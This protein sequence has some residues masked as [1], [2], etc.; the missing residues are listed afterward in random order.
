MTGVTNDRPVGRDAVV[1]AV[2]DAAATLFAER[3]PA[4]VSLREVAAAANVNLGL[5]HRYVGS[6]DDLLAAALTL[7]PGPEAFPGGPEVVV[8]ALLVSPDADVHR[9][10]RLFVQAALDGYDVIR[11]QRGMPILASVAG[12][13]RE[14]LPDVDA[15]MRAAL[16]GSMIFGWHAL[17]R[18]YLGELG[19]AN[20]SDVELAALARPA[21]DAFFA[22]APTG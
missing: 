21:I 11:L 8:E 5:I 7:R 10:I 12:A 19:R 2:I 16:M 9:Y 18:I 17:G 4:A 13:L 15:D 22:A 14:R 20:L 6:K 1:A 3:G